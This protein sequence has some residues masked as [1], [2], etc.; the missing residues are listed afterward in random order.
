M[1][2]KMEYLNFDFFLHIINKKYVYINYRI[3][4]GVFFSNI[5]LPTTCF[6][7]QFLTFFCMCF[8]L[9]QLFHVNA[10]GLILVSH[11]N[12]LSS[13]WKHIASPAGGEPMILQ[14]DLR[15]ILAYTAFSPRWKFFIPYLCFVQKLF[16]SLVQKGGRF[17]IRFRRKGMSFWEDIL[18]EQCRFAL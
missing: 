14:L 7:L 11:Q 3:F 8:F 15:K 9:K 1:N 4:K 12:L 18:T 2:Q 10:C 5:I 6:S 17:F 13:Y 16:F